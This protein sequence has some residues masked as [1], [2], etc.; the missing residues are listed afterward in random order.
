MKK[1]ERKIRERVKKEVSSFDS[2][3]RQNEL[4]LVNMQ[5]YARQTKPKEPVKKKFDWGKLLLNGMVYASMVFLVLSVIYMPKNLSEQPSDDGIRVEQ[6]PEYIEPIDQQKLFYEEVV[7]EYYRL[8]VKS[9][10]VNMPFEDITTFATT[11]IDGKLVL[12][13]VKGKIKTT[14]DSYIVNFHFPPDANYEFS[15]MNDYKNLSTEYNNLYNYTIN[16]NTE[17]V[18]E[19][20][21]NYKMQITY[22]KD[23]VCYLDM[24]CTQNNFEDFVNSV[25]TQP[26]ID[27][28]L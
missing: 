20:T 16:Y 17:C 11:N 6:P 13:S 26:I 25:F 23:N 21:Y 22:Q 12:T 15:G 1:F 28:T 5:I 3:Y 4:K 27:A 7:E 14:E 9:M 19:N 2:W 18:A 8:V 10:G 24:Y